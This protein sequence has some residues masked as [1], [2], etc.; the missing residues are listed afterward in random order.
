[1]MV[2]KLEKLFNMINIF[3]MIEQLQIQICQIII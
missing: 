1:M 3:I 2:M